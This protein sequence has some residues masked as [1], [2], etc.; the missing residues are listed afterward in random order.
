MTR[1]P[2]LRTR[3]GELLIDG[4]Y[5]ALDEVARL[6]RLGQQAERARN[7]RLPLRDPPA[8]GPLATPEDIRRAREALPKANPR[9]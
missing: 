5:Y 4:R 8:P 7:P 2:H 9:R 3:G 6:F 1:G